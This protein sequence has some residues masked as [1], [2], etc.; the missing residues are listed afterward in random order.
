MLLTSQYYMFLVFVPHY[1]HEISCCLLGAVQKVQ[2][3][4]QTEIRTVH[5]GVVQLSTEAPPGKVVVLV[6]VAVI[7]LA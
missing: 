4:N 6:V 5:Y 2:L 1:Q 3:G 7:L